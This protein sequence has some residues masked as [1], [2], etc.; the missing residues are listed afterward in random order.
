[1]GS[2]GEE[3]G[4]GWKRYVRKQ[5]RVVDATRAK[6]AGG[7]RNAGT[8]LET[9]VRRNGASDPAIVSPFSL[10]SALIS[11]CALEDD[12]SRPSSSLLAPRA[13]LVL[14][15]VLLRQYNRPLARSRCAIIADAMFRD[16]LEERFAN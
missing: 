14:F 7:A 4:R 8:G 11:R 12:T 3:G 2:G 5:K 13:P 1:M 15:L 10:S 6:G 9:L 16:P